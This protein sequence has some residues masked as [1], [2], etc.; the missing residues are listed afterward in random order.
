MPNWHWQCWAN[1]QLRHFMI[2]LNG[3]VVLLLGARDAAYTFAIFVQFHV[4]LD[5]L[6]IV[7]ITADPLVLAF[8]MMSQRGKWMVGR[9]ASCG[10]YGAVMR[11]NI[12]VTADTWV[13]RVWTTASHGI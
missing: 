6:V 9:A 12:H 8:S 2:S 10:A 1:I 5:A 11:G 3:I 7:V 4:L 13:P